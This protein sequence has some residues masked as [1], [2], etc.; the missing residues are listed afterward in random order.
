YVHHEHSK[1]FL[2]GVLPFKAEN[3][4]RQRPEPL[5]MTLSTPYVQAPIVI[6]RCPRQKRLGLLVHVPTREDAF[7]KP[8][9]LSTTKTFHPYVMGYPQKDDQLKQGNS[10]ISPPT[11]R[12]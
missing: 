5:V 12:P 6:R 9:M 3:G 1:L 7:P 10:Q 11:E 8:C 4:T 2:D